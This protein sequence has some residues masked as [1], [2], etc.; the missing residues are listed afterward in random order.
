M[1]DALS[2]Q[3][4]AD[5]PRLSALLQRRHS[6]RAFLP[7]PVP[8]DL[9]G[10]ILETA[11]ST[12]SWC[13]AQPWRVYIVS[14]APLEAL[15]TE[16]LARAQSNTPPAPE[17]DWPREYRGIYRERRRECGWALYRA[18]GVEQGDRD[19]S[20]Q[21]ARENFRLFGAPHL[22][23]MTSDEALGTHGVMDCG[24]WVANFMLAATAAGVGSIAQ[25]ALASWPDVLRKHLDIP[26]DRRVVCGISFGYEDTAHPANS[27]R[28]RRAAVD[29]TV[30]LIG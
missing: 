9:I 4:D 25:A 18:V 19:A 11:R 12:A 14:G 23:I 1:N 10:Q 16:L 8:R 13:N 24:A 6:C 17:L 28:T 21:Q 27:F 26:A 3:Q 5:L 30:T 2:P 7:Q 20:A 29:E 22:A 15:R